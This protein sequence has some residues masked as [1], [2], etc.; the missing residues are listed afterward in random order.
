MDNGCATI[1][2]TVEG[3][4]KRSND[5]WVE[6]NYVGPRYFSTIGVKLLRGREIT[7]Q[8]TSRTVPI[9]VVNIEFEREFLNG[10]GALGRMV[11][12][13]GRDIQIVGVAEN[14]RSDNIHQ[15]ALPYLFLPVEQAPGGWNVSHLEIRALGNASAIASSVRAVILG[16]NRAIPVAEISTLANEI[17]RGLASEL[18]VGRLAGL[19]SALTLMIAAIGLYGILA[20]E[21]TLRRPEFAVRIALGATKQNIISVVFL[22][23]FLIWIAGSTAGLLLSVSVARFTKS[24]LFETGPLDGATYG[25]TLVALL[26]VSGIAVF[27]PA[28]RAASL[29]PAS[30]LRSE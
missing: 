3:A 25:A 12:V 19:F 26:V 1:P 16:V 22:R 29:D 28:R 21:V 23:A 30:S 8:D 4:L 11:H 13:E 6:R 7:E 5:S 10:Q 17:N 2:A 20:Y 15:R 27:F 18:L 9:A 24:L 14:A